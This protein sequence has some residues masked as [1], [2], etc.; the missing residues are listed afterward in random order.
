MNLEKLTQSNI[1]ETLGLDQ[2][3]KEAQQ[4]AINEAKGIIL[5]NIADA[6]RN[7]I[8]YRV[9]DEFERVLSEGTDEERGIFLK[10]HVPNLQDLLAIETLRYKHLTECIAASERRGSAKE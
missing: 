6:I 2:A 10:K 7:Q 3:P 4:E 5:E 8:P 9:H 1:L